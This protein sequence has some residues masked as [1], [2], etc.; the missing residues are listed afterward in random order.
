MFRWEISRK[1]AMDAKTLMFSSAIMGVFLS[2]ALGATEMG[3][4]PSRLAVIQSAPDFDLTTH[5]GE[6]LRRRDLKNKVCLVSFIFTTCNGTCP[7]TTHRMVQVED[8][9]KAAGMWKEDNVQLLSITLDPARDTPEK[10]RHYMQ[11]YGADDTHWTFL[12]GSADRIAQTIAAWGMWTKPMPNGQIDHPSRIYLV[13]SKSQVREIY[14]LSFMDPAWV[15][16][17]IQL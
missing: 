9:L 17:D 15:V 4:A 1:D 6:R 5:N 3:P 11:L 16:K 7:A 10:L 12:T 8:A 2:P 14:N 13:D